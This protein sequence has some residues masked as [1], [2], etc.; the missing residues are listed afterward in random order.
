MRGSESNYVVY[1]YI[2]PRDNE[3]FYIGRGTLHRAYVHLSQHSFARQYT[4]PFAQRVSLMLSQEVYPEVHIIRGGLTSD[5]AWEAEAALIYLVGRQVT[6]GS[7][8]NIHA[9]R[10]EP[11]KGYTLRSAYHVQGKQ[12]VCWGE[13][14]PS[15]AAAA[16][17]PR[18]NV[19]VD[20][21]YRR[22]TRGWSPERAASTIVQGAGRE[23]L[24]WGELFPSL[25]AVSRDS[26]CVVN[27]DTLYHRVKRG[28]DVERAASTPRDE[29]AARTV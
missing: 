18:S 24:C 3:P 8:C 15:Y 2:D 22:A 28:W 20:Q 17:D 5:Q 10:E 14:F 16:R 7:L 4:S 23:S 26:R 11:A 21:M 9:G 12:C 19:T 29:V 27:Q 6:G 13:T 25:A 1:A